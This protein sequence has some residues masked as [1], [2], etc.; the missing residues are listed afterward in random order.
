MKTSSKAPLLGLLLLLFTIPGFSQWSD[1][2]FLSIGG[3]AGIP[4]NKQ[5]NNYSWAAGGY[6]KLSLPLGTADY[7]TL[8]LNALSI[9]GK[10]LDNGKPLKEHDILTGYIGYRFDFRKED[11]YSYFFMEPQV[12]W[13]FSG[14]DYNSFAV[15]PMVGY[16]LNSKVDIAAFYQATTTST[17]LAKVGVGGIAISYNFHFTRRNDY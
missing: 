8:S 5:V 10:G 11:S 3:Q 17:R 7:L 14:T 15:Q 4:F 13:C 6:G 1:G 9:N 2:P 16:S 12:G